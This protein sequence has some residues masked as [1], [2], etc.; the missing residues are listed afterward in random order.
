MKIGYLIKIVNTVL[1]LISRDPVR[2]C[3]LH[4]SPVRK[5]L[6]T[7]CKEKEMNTVI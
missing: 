2:S 4:I 7:E 1:T 5:E 6:I 3:D